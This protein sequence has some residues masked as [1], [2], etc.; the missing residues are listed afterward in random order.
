MTIGVNS[1]QQS[2]ETI[3]MTMLRL[4]VQPSAK[5]P[6][7]SSRVS[8]TACVQITGAWHGAVTLDCPIT[9]ARRVASIML[10]LPP[11]EVEPD[12]VHDALGE[13]VNIIGGNFKSLLPEPTALSLPA[14]AQGTDYAI[15]ILDSQVLS[16]LSFTCG[17]SSFVV[18]IVQCR[19]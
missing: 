16:R 17:E 14:V 18:T 10:E 11:N 2:V 5:H 7:L 19:S 9:L 4:D 13:L 3:W 6:T 1:I 15:R 8:L 12:L